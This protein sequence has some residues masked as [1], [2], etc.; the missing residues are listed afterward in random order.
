MSRW[1]TT[2]PRSTS[3]SSM[4]R[5]STR[6]NIFPRWNL[7]RRW[8]FK[9]LGRKCCPVSESF[10]KNT[11]RVYKVFQNFQSNNYSYFSLIYFI[12]LFECN[13]LANTRSFFFFFWLQ[14]RISCTTRWGVSTSIFWSPARKRPNS[15]QRT[16]KRRLQF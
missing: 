14:M 5:W 8:S 1:Q 3:T 10:F 12:Y 9:N 16:L 6:R 15:S 4:V 2:Q 11:I 7:R 13:K